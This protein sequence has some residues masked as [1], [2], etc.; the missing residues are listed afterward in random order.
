MFKDTNNLKW[1]Y[2]QRG[3]SLILLKLVVF[4]PKLKLFTEGFFREVKTNLNYR[5]LD[6]KFWIIMKGG[7]DDWEQR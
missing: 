1:I 7:P 6:G 3:V 4:L 2:I 5:M